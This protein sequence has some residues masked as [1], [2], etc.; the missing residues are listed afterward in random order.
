MRGRSRVSY[1]TT[2]RLSYFELAEELFGAASTARPF[3]RICTLMRQCRAQTVVVHRHVE[4]ERYYR[5]RYPAVVDEIAHLPYP[6]TVTQVTFV[7][8]AIPKARR[9]LARA[10][11]GK[12][13]GILATCVIITP[14]PGRTG[15]KKKRATR[16]P[17]P[18]VYEAVVTFPSVPVA[19]RRIQLL[20]NYYHVRDGIPVWV[21]GREHEL[22]GAYF[23][24]QNGIT[25]ACAHSAIKMALWH[26]KDDY[27]LSTKRINDTARANARAEA[28]EGRPFRRVSPR[29]GLT[30]G[31]IQA[32]CARVGVRT[33]VMDCEKQPGAAPFEFAY[34]LVESGIP[35]IMIFTP[36]PQQPQVQHTVPV[37]GHDMNVD[38]WLPAAVENYER[39]SR[40]GL[41]SSNRSHLSSVEYAAHLLVHDDLL[42]PY[43]GLD[44]NALSNTLLKSKDDGGRVDCIIGVLPQSLELP[45][46]PYFAQQA[47]SR[48]FQELW[49]AE[50][51]GVR[52]PWKKRL[53]AE[54]FKDT[55]LVL[56]TLAMRKEHYLAWLRNAKDHKGRRAEI[57]AATRKVLEHRLPERFWM[58]EFSLPRLFTANKGKLGEMLLPLEAAELKGVEAPT[59]TVRLPEPYVFRFV[60]RLN[61]YDHGVHQLDFATHTPLFRQHGKIHEY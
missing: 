39:L 32:V 14:L 57:T 12:P 15:R 58:V 55:T 11:P 46:A 42:G 52:D 19:G 43:M 44:R 8:T 21:L 38:L 50:L 33:F 61:A 5:R 35:T 47:A 7:E 26:A 34:L 53:E 60:N 36:D 22:E 2:A 17:G 13:S 37:L 9:Q 51:R 49:R 48:L 31:D 29:R 41:V 40:R 30:I 25:S 4:Q 27:Q 56:R 24:Q 23:C 18:Y 59:D 16:L 45:A 54:P 1:L 10:E 3:T 6:A 20:H 28:G